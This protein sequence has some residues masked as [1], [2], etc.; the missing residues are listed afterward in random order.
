[1]KRNSDACTGDKRRLL[2]AVPSRRSYNRGIGSD[3]LC[4]PARHPD[5][6]TGI[7]LSWHCDER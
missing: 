3:L 1:M 7:C 4:F 5:I 2:K 6:R